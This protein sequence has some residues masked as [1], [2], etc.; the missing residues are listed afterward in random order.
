MPVPVLN[1]RAARVVRVVRAPLVVPDL[2]RKAQVPQRTIN[3]GCGE[4][5]AAVV[6]AQP[7]A[8]ARIGELRQVCNDVRVERIPHP[9]DRI[10][11]EVVLVCELPENHARVAVGAILD[12]MNPR[13]LEAHCADIGVV[14]TRVRGF[15]DRGREREHIGDIVLRELVVHNEDARAQGIIAAPSRFKRRALRLR[16]GRGVPVFGDQRTGACAV[17]MVEASDPEFTIVGASDRVGTIVD[18]RVALD[19]D[20][21]ARE[22]ERTLIAHAPAHADRVD[23][24]VGRC[25]QRVELDQST[26]DRNQGWGVRFEQGRELGR[27]LCVGAARNCADGD[28]RVWRCGI[29]DHVVGSSI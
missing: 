17:V 20:R 13:E 26:L 18:P 3:I 6:R 23:L 25:V 11:S 4:H 2:V 22:H 24:L 14:V 9:M 1:I 19:P 16:V 5:V 15:H 28:Q 29:P 27:V 10:E 12:L 21:T 8:S 7:P